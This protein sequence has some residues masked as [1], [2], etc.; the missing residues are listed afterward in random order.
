MNDFFS[1]DW[2]WIAQFGEN[3][4]EAMGFLFIQGGWVIFVI[5]FLW[6]L[7]H[8][9]LDW[10]QHLYAHKRQYML[11]S[12]HIPRVSEQGPRAVDN[13]F[14]YLA[15][16]HSPATWKE[17]WI[18]GKFQELI[19]LE[20]VSIEGQVMFMIHTVR[21]YRDLIEA[22]IYSQYP[23]AEIVEVQDYV[24]NV[25]QHYPSE[26]WDLWGTEM[27]PVKSD[28]YPLKTY[29]F[30]EDKVSGEFKDPLSA[31]LESFSRLGPGEQAWFQILL[32][33]IAQGEF[34]E[35]AI[36]AVKKL[37]GEETPH[38]TSLIEHIVEFPI[39]VL[40]WLL[41]GIMGGEGHAEAPKKSDSTPKILRM[42]EGE[43]QVLSG[44]EMKMSKL[45]YL[46][47]LRFIYVAKKQV[48]QKSHIVQPFIG[49]IKQFN[50][51]N[52]QSLKPESK[53]VGINGALWW[54]KESRN[55]TRKTHLISAYRNRSDWFGTPS[56]HLNTEELASL[57]HFPHTMQVKAPQVQKTESKRTEPPPNL[58][59]G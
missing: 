40:G 15:G 54:F 38:K 57:W 17:A 50:T 26:E 45:V 11:L 16:A 49:S 48:M 18:D 10:R 58:P 41:E 28:V 35:K 39:H 43:K 21:N 37:K 23:D 59:F 13:M 25:P 4:F 31:M 12:I 34:A 2:S 56:Y 19:S 42:S 8:A 36:A 52:M 6:M 27:I 7:E 5:L 1:F 20:L 46:C 53:K 55:N 3:P 51:N 9:W 33:P 32:K 44:I 47:T 29:P 30:F 22:A 14:A 24:P